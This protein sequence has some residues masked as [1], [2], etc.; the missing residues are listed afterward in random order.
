MKRIRRRIFSSYLPPAES[1]FYAKRL[2]YIFSFTAYRFEVRPFIHHKIYIFFYI[3]LQSNFFTN[4]N[5]CTD[6]MVR[7]IIIYLN[8]VLPLDPNQ[9]RYRCFSR[10]QRQYL[11]MRNK[12]WRRRRVKRLHFVFI[13][14]SNRIELCRERK[15][16]S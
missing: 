14:P 8:I 16:H 9:I 7:K 11:W 3:F 10:F 2:R 4:F 6:A 15:Q 12:P 5:I 13:R 1:L